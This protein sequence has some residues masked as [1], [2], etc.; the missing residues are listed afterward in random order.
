MC[1]LVKKTIFKRIILVVHVYKC[2]F[3]KFQVQQH[4]QWRITPFQNIA[5]MCC[6][7]IEC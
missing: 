4:G 1:L 6:I 2:F 5:K 7:A 3:L